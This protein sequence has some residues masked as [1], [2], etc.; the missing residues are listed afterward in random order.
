MFKVS[1]PSAFF[2]AESQM[3]PVIEKYLGFPD[4]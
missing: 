1:Y 4:V 2:A 3:K